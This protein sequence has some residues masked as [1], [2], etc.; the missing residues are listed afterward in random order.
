MTVLIEVLAVLAWLAVGVLA[1]VGAL[2]LFLGL[3]VRADLRE[4]R[5]QREESA[6]IPQAVVDRWRSEESARL[7]RLADRYERAHRGVA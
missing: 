6:G 4:L 3:L 1:L 7:A 2:A 5:R